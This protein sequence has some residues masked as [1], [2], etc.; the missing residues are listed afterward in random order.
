M[1]GQLQPGPRYLRGMSDSA[2]YE[3]DHNDAARAVTTLY[4]LADMVDAPEGNLG[5]LTD[6]Q[7]Q[8]ITSPPGLVISRN[9]SASAGNLR[10]TARAI[11]EQMPGAAPDTSGPYALHTEHPPPLADSAE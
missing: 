2:R 3:I 7:M 10:R 6:N 1:V 4:A 11:E 8:V 5:R 9:R